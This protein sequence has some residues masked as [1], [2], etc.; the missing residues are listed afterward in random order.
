[1]ELK[2]LHK[3][4]IESLEDVKGNDLISID[5]RGKIDLIDMMVIASGTSDRHVQALADNVVEKAKKAGATVVGVEK[6]RAWV[7]VDLYDIIVHVMLPEAREFYN[8]EK[9]WQLDIP[10]EKTQTV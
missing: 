4:V 3:L 8:L 1:V 10:A 5:M 2:K 6:D 7:L 9:L